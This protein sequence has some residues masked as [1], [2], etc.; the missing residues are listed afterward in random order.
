MTRIKR[1]FVAKKRRKKIFKLV[2]GFRGSHSK[3]FAT[4]NQQYMKALKYSYADRK[5]N[6]RNFKKIW[7]QRIKG[8]VENFGVK[9]NQLIKKLKAENSGLNRKMLAIIALEDPK[10]LELVLIKN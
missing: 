8:L 6:K 10:T 9:Y 3:L 4:A 1:G 5:K 7:I 2:K